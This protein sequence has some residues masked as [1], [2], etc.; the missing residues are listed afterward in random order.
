M[1]KI[2]GKGGG[3]GRRREKEEKEKK[4]RGG[5]EEEGGARRVRDRECEEDA[6]AIGRRAVRGLGGR[7]G[8]ARRRE[9][10]GYVGG[11]CRIV[12]LRGRCRIELSYIYIYVYVYIHICI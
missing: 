5:T 8:W 4:S 12:I 2:E 11:G 10:M 6:R 7:D 9:E 3:G 1:K